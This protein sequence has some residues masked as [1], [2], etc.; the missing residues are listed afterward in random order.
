MWTELGAKLPMDRAGGLGS[1]WTEWEA[2]LPVDRA[3]LG[4]EWRELG[5]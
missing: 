1:V 5:G 3:G 4:S 2:G